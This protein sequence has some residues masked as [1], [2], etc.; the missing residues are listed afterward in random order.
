MALRFIEHSLTD[1]EILKSLLSMTD[2]HND[3]VH[4]R[5]QNSYMIR[6]YSD[7]L[8]GMNATCM[9]SC[10]MGQTMTVGRVKAPT[11]KLVYDNS[12]AIENF[13]QR[14]Y[15][16]VEADYGVFTGTL[17]GP[18]A[19]PWQADS[20][21][22]AAETIHQIS[23]NGKV[24]KKTQKDRSTHAPK[25]YDLTSIQAE[26]GS[27]YGYTPAKTLSIIQSLYEKHKVISYPRTQCRYVS[28]EKAKEFPMMLQKMKV[29]EELEPFADISLDAIER[30]M[31]DKN[32]VNDKEVEKESHDALLPTSTTPN[33]G[34]MT[35]EERNIC[36]MIYRR[37]LAQFLPLLEEK[38]TQLQIS[39]PRM[40]G[41]SNAIF[42]VSGRVVVEPGWSVLYSQLSEKELPDFIEGDVVAAQSIKAVEK[43][44]NPPKR[45]T[46]A[47]LIAAMKNI[48]SLIE[49]KE[50]K[51]SLADSQGIGTPA[52]R[53]G[54]IEDII[55]R[56]YVKDEKG[57]YITALGRAY[58]ESLASVDIIKPEFAAVMD[59]KLKKIQRGEEDF[60]KVYDEVIDSLYTVCEQIDAIQKENITVNELCPKCHR[61]KLEIDSYYYTCPDENCGLRLSKKI[62]GVDIDEKILHTIL[63]G[64]KTKK[65]NFK[66]KDGK[67]FKAMLYMKDLQ[68]QFD[69]SSGIKCPYCHSDV[70]ANKGGWFCDCGLKIFK[71]MCSRTFKESEVKQLLEKKRLDNLTGF[72]NRDGKPYPPTDIYLDDDTKTVKIIYNS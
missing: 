64:K 65:M 27:K 60:E 67:T 59:T 16:E 37:L 46:Q 42:V 5:F 55:R 23:K 31:R 32:V 4:I 72:A 61:K 11:I 26:V 71:T 51:E 44:T 19:K 17:Y 24:V 21:E 50:L 38:R 6:S 58:I 41:N 12:L 30:V 1:A 7:W 25:L 66:K 69:F 3:E 53:A 68:Y 20:A 8:F 56:G 47:S 54:I 70:R 62:C 40:D 45:L 35:E 22:M 39:H 28:S 48:A 9:M 15:Y 18:D 36:L 63:T 34:T 13:R 33:L 49:D 2:Y 29:F 52:T 43:K 10:K 57:L 14:K